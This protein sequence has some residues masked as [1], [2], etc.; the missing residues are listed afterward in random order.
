ML[1]DD[2]ILRQRGVPLLP[3]GLSKLGFRKTSSEIAGALRTKLDA[4][5]RSIEARRT[6]IEALIDEDKP[7]KPVTVETV[8]KLVERQRYGRYGAYGHLT[9]PAKR[10]LREA[11]ALLSERAIVETLALANEH[12]DESR[13][14]ADSYIELSFGDIQFLFS[15]YDASAV[16]G[17]DDEPDIGVPLM[18]E[19]MGLGTMVRQQQGIVG[20]VAQTGPSSLS[21]LA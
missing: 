7:T 5:Q 14:D 21:D 11:R 10:A 13:S 17:D 2:A 1:F 18:P 19:P 20:A 3:L 12:F 15:E 6:R 4:V 8:M 16:F 9:E